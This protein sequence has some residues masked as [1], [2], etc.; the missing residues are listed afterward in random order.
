MELGMAT[1][2]PGG[3]LY[4]D[5]ADILEQ[6]SECEMQFD[7]D[8]EDK[9][10]RDSNMSS[11]L[12]YNSTGC[13]QQELHWLQEVKKTLESASSFLMVTS[14]FYWIL[15]DMLSQSSR[16]KPQQERGPVFEWVF[17]LLELLGFVVFVLVIGTMILVGAQISRL[18]SAML[19][20][21]AILMLVR[22]VD[23]LS[24]LCVSIM[25]I[26]LIGWHLVIEK[27][28]PNEWEMSIKGDLRG[29]N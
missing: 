15:T 19:L 26:I 28:P 12:Q 10:K 3:K 4:D 20:S 25:G 22:S 1:K 14:S 17:P 27:Q 23:S 11:N 29:Q 13:N 5:S 7:L 16:V 2:V 8:R 18:Q 6:Q 24:A 9:L 21:W